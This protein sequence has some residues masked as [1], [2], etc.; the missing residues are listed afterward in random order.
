MESLRPE[1]LKQHPGKWVVMHEGD[2]A[3]VADSLEGALEEVDRL[4]LP[5]GEAVIEFLDPK[6]KSM[7]L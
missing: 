4:E 6:P 3:I 5:R 2:I 1:L 7:I